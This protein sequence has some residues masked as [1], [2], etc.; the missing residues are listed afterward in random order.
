MIHQLPPRKVALRMV[1]S[2]HR[3][4]CV[5]HMQRREVVVDVLQQRLPIGEMM[6]LVDEKMR[7]AVRIVVVYEVHQVV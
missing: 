4:A 5:D 7:A 1:D 2:Q 3:R 6:H